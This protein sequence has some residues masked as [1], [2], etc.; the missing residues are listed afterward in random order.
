MYPPGTQEYFSFWDEEQRRCT[1][2]Y[3]AEDGDYITG[4]NYFY[5]NYCPI[6]RMVYNTISDGKGGTKVQRKRITEF[7]SFYDYDYYFFEA[8]QEAEEQG[9]HLCLLKS[10][11]KGYSYKLASMSCRN[12]YMVPGSKSYI[13]ASDAQ[14]LVGDGTFT[15][16]TGYMSF[17]DK[18][19]AFAKKKSINKTLH[20]RAGFY[21]KDE[22]G[23]EVEMGFKSEIIGASLKDNPSKV[24]G[25]A[26]K[27]ILFEEGGSFPELA[28]AWS[29]ARPS[30]E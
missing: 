11:R 10:R 30:V 24:R 27:L 19:T 4:Y 5:L 8:V 22:Y 2:G 29:I 9:K 26:G 21:T 16:V 20:K 18:N 15:K 12:Y 1:E 7:P 23:N 17:I 13:Y 25:K 6:D 3:T 14:Y 28:A